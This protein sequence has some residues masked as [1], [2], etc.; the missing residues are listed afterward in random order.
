M[1]TRARFE[2][3]HWVFTVP[4]NKHHIA[5]TPQ[6]KTQHKPPGLATMVV[7]EVPSTYQDSHLAGKRRASQGSPLR[8]TQGVPLGM[9]GDPEPCTERYWSKLLHVL[10]RHVRLERRVSTVPFVLFG[11]SDVSSCAYRSGHSPTS[12]RPSFT[13]ST[14]LVVPTKP[15]R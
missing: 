9:G 2:W 5:H 11:C 12:S 6:H 4:H 1:Y 8:V 14:G 10:G 7:V 15:P 13:V 3:T